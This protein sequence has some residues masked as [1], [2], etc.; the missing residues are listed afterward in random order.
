MKLIM[1]KLTN[2]GKITM[3]TRTLTIK[4]QYDGYK[5]TNRRSDGL[6]GKK[7]DRFTKVYPQ[8]TSQDMSD[9]ASIAGL[10]YGDGVL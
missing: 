7:S 5:Y 2:Q 6:V 3:Y 4:S 9:T 1:T 10:F 8:I